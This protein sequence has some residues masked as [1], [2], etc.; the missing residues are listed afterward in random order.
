MIIKAP[1]LRKDRLT[2]K[3]A[4]TLDPDLQLYSGRQY[5]D[6]EK[7]TFGVFLDSSP[8]R[9][10]RSLLRRR[11]AVRAR[12]KKRSVKRFLESDYLLGVH[13]KTRMGGLRFKTDAAGPFLNNDYELSVPPW[14]SLRELEVACSHF[15]EDPNY[16]NEHEKWIDILLAPGSSLGGARPKSNVM[17]NNGDLWIAKFPSRTDDFNS[18]AWEMV[19][20]ELA[21]KSGLSL[22]ECRIEKFSKRG[23]TF[24]SK[25]FDRTSTRR[26]HFA[27]AMTLLGKSDGDD[28]DSGCGY[29]DLARFIVQ[30]GGRP[31][32]DLK[33]LW[34]RIVFSIAISNTDDHLRNHGFLLTPRGWRLSPAFDLN[35]N[36]TGTGLSLNISS[37][38]NSLD[39][40]LALSVAPQFRLTIRQAKD[41]ISSIKKIVG[42]WRNTALTLKI[43]RDEIES[44]APAFNF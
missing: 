33:E 18:G 2:S 12:Q 1:K 22:P 11:E 44:M 4:L 31:A 15:E 10:G 7:N 24:L 5:A 37:D 40:E 34:R 28:C 3:Q 26:I 9:W 41:Q 43:R 19:V 16:E 29:L 23:T 35:P 30:Y 13:D 38:D 6:S 32:G 25:R 21:L 39:F 17:D 14:T 42:T 8:D 27:S 36:S 20:Y